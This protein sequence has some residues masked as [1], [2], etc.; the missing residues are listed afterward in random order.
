[1]ALVATETS[2]QSSEMQLFLAVLPRAR[3]APLCQN[4]TLCGH[5]STRGIVPRA[6]PGCRG[7]GDGV[8]YRG[9]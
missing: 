3:P 4:D 7:T 8:P 6:W 1:M 9:P 5:G 2:K